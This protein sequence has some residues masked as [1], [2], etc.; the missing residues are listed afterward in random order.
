[1][2]LSLR[3]AKCHLSKEILRITAALLENREENGK[4]NNC[5]RTFQSEDT[6]KVC[7]SQG[8]CHPHRE[9]EGR[10]RRWWHSR[11]WKARAESHQPL[12]FSEAKIF[13]AEL[14]LG[15][16]VKEQSFPLTYRPNMC[17]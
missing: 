3:E 14:D 17:F 9:G 4:R 11:V 1:M 2:D 7:S 10:R 13:K 12:K 16:Q 5:H 8:V 15:R 6:E